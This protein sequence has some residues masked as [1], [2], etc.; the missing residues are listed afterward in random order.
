MLSLDSIFSNSSDIAL[1]LRRQACT[2][3]SPQILFD[4]KAIF[5]C[6]YHLLSRVTS[7]EDLIDHRD[8]QAAAV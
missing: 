7:M 5:K 1:L 2:E 3:E 4:L 6:S 8:D